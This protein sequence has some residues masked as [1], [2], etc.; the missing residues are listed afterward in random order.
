MSDRP[1][2]PIRS[3]YVAG[4]TATTRGRDDDAHHDKLAAWLAEEGCPVELQEEQL[5]DALLVRCRTE[6]VEPDDQVPH[7][8]AP[9]YR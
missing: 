4:R 9:G 2:R 8:T 6:R 3:D 7:R 5:H 1:T